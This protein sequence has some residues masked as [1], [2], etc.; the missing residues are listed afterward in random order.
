LFLDCFFFF[1]FPFRVSAARGSD[2]DLELL[3]SKMPC[4]RKYYMSASQ[5]LPPRRGKLRHSDH[6]L[7]RITQMVSLNKK[8]D[9]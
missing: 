9:T 3:M 6:H 2:D 1:F 8:P 5:K 7:S 4:R